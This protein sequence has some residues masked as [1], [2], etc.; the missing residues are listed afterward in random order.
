MK[1]LYIYLFMSL[2]GVETVLKNR[3]EGFQAIGVKADFI[4]LE[5]HGGGSSFRTLQNAQVFVTNDHREIEKIISRGDYDVITVIDTPQVHALLRNIAKSQ[6]VIM[7]VHTPHPLMRKYI[8]TDVIEDAIAVIVPTAT[9]GKMVESEM[10]RPH[11]PIIPLPN[12]INRL[13]LKNIENLPKRD[14]V[15]IAYV[16]RIEQIKDWKESTKIVQHV[17][18]RHKNIDFFMV[19]R[20]IDEKPEDIFRAFS[21]QGLTGHVRWIPFIEYDRM[22]LFYNYISSNNGVYLTS[23]KGESFGMT[24]IES[25]SC[26]LPVVAC[27]LPVFHEVLGEGT[28]GKIYRSVEEAADHILSFIEKRE[29]R[30][31]FVMRAYQHVLNDYT[32]GVFAEKW[33]ALI[34][35]ER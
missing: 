30:E 24:L 33:S 14:R 28:F 3:C 20:L 21:R 10:K 11:P 26:K 25:M 6:K 13:F 18:R 5:D 8:Q 35:L 2:G 31:L 23:S 19:G 27:N 16:G 1:I 29:E 34:N 17:V 12:P 9:F 7:E 15:P 4:F 22:P 32:S